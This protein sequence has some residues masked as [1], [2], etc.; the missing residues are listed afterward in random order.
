MSKLNDLIAELCPDGVEYA[1]IGSLITRG[2]ERGKYNKEIQQVYVV[3]NSMGMVKAEEFRE[4]TIHSEDTSNYTVIKPGMYAYNP[5]RLNIG[6]IAM[7]KDNTWGL[8][9]P[10]YVVFSIDESKII[11]E[12]FEYTIKSTFVRN[13]I[14]TLK[15]EGARFRFDFNRWDWIQIPIPPLSIQEE[16]IRILDKFTSLE[17]EL[18]AELEARR[19][20]YEYYRD[21][22]LTFGNEVERKT[23]GEVCSSIVSGKNKKRI[24]NGKFPVYGSTGVI[25]YTDEYSY[26]EELLLV[27]RVGANCGFVNKVEGK[28]DVSDNTLIIKVNKN[29]NLNFAYYQLTNM[30]LNN[31]SIGGG[32]PLITAGKLKSLYIPIPPLEEQER[33]VAILDRFDALVNDISQGIPAEIEARRKQYEYYR[34]KL[35]TFKEVV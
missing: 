10:M 3:S 32:Q 31:L 21:S 12:Y 5:S 9:S 19:Q 14:K 24:Q 22:L 4:N 7:L 16:I 1:S 13:K 18:E 27:A 25:G 20:Q 15:E 17:A 29:Y 26:N 2:R 6:S 33:I 23:L 28:I 34:D 30:N 35:L 8:V 11:K